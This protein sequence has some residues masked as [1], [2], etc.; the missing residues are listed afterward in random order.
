MEP[1]TTCIASIVDM[2]KADQMAELPYVDSI[3][4]LIKLQQDD[5][6]QT[7]GC[8][9]CA[10]FRVY[11]ATECTSLIGVVTAV[12]FKPHLE[13]ELD[14]S[15]THVVNWA[16][17]HYYILRPVKGVFKYKTQKRKDP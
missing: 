12:H 15:T 4:G 17:Y 1:D 13:V 11:E 10:L 3:E 7:V 14:N 2:I 6:R 5:I 8:T 9:G 16:Y